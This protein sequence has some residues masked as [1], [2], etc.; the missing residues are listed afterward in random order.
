MDIKTLQAQVGHDDIN[1]TL[2]VYAAVTADMR[3]T[4]VDKFTSLVNF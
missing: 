2:N 4:T 3:A 1:T